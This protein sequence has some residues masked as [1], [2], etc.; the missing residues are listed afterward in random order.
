MKIAIYSDLHI[1]ISSWTPPADVVLEA[2]LVLLAGD[3][4]SHTH[5]L[6]WARQAFPDKRLIMINGNH[7][8]YGAEYH[9]MLKECRK[10]ATELGII[11]L[12]ND[13]YID[14][15]H[16][17]RFLGC[18]LWTDFKLFGTG[19]TYALAL[20]E[21]VHYMTDFSVIRFSPMPVFR[22]QDS[23]RLHQESRAWLEE[24]LS[25]PFEGKTV[26]V[27]HHVPTKMA[28]APQYQ[29][30]ILSAA[31]ASNLDAL[32]SRADYW[33]A[34]HTHVACDVQVGKCHVIVNPRGNI[35]SGDQRVNSEDTGWDRKLMVEV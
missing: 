19:E 22:P 10:R 29:D 24:R 32:V 23:V 33:I 3:I 27:T 9:G 28:V 18:T 11:F 25:E 4:G 34:G 14:H 8:Y 20:R 31:F 15:E 1:E 35:W 16:N 17:V 12:E 7:E 2:D 26:V 30:E 5:G 21:A 6:E 13:E